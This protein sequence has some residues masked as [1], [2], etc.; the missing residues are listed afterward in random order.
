MDQTTERRQGSTVSRLLAGRSYLWV[1]A[2]TAPALLGYAIYGL[3]PERLAGQ[4]WAVRFYPVS[5]QIFA[6]LHI[7]VAAA[8]LFTVLFKLLRLSWVPAF[9][10]VAVLSF[11]AEHIGTGYGFPFGGYSYTGLLGYKIGGRVPALI[12]V[13]WFLMSLPS[14]VLA[15]RAFPGASQRVRRIVLAAAWLVAWDLALDPAMSYLTPY[16]QWEATGPYYGMP[17]VNLAGWFATG[18]V[19]M[20]ALDLFAQRVP[21]TRLQPR[22]AVGYY[23]AILTMPVGMLVAAGAW[24]AVAATTLG[25]GACAATTWSTEIRRVWSSSSARAPEAVEA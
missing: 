24:P 13:S 15:E 5:F 25:V 10:T 2:F 20:A 23:L 21:L 4:D 14:W 7:V 22:W 19:L 6:R 16:W 11:L 18:L 1:L 12:P 9:L 3:H 8:V 17:W